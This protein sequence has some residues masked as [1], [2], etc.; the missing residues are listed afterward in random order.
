MKPNR[1]A[2][3]LVI[4]FCLTIFAIGLMFILR[5]A[6]PGRSGGGISPTLA[7]IMTVDAREDAIATRVAEAL[8]QQLGV[9]ATFVPTI[10]PTPLPTGIN[11]D[12]LVTPEAIQDGL[13]TYTTRSGDTVTALGLRFGIENAE[14]IA[15]GA[16]SPTGY[17]PIGQLI[18]VPPYLG[19]TTLPTLLLPDAA[20]VYGPL[21]AGF[22]VSTYV[23]D[24][25][26]YLAHYSENV[27]GTV[28]S[29]ADIVKRVALE[30]SIS[31]KLLLAILEYRSGWVLSNKTSMDGQQYPLG[32][33]IA[34]A[35]GL[36]E[37]LYIAGRQLAYGFYGWRD[38]TRTKIRFTDGSEARLHPEINAGTAAIENL[39][40]SLDSPTAW[41]SHLFGENS[42]GAVYA[43]MFG[44]PWEQS[45]EPLIP[46]GLSQP[47]LELP[48]STGE[49]YH[50]TSGPHR[51][52]GLGSPWA[53]IDFAPAD[54]LKGCTVS[55]Y[56][57]TASAPGL[58]VRSANGVVVIDLDGDGFEQTGWV[59][60]Y[61]HLAE[62]DRVQAGT[63]VEQDQ[64][65]GH[66]SCV[67]GVATGSHVH[68]AR[69]YY[70]EW[71]HAAGEVPLV[72]SGWLVISGDGEYQGKLMREGM[73]VSSY[74]YSIADSRIS[75]D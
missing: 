19:A 18:R 48:F 49:D 6:F 24:A 26:G 32:Y 25:D 39:F 3:M 69:K 31:A 34:D 33:G 54:G 30:H 42:F 5:L 67:G 23:A 37:E 53:A 51:A 68:F 29:G 9:S 59:L 16:S 50:L 44:I 46:D 17:L 45:T 1:F 70:G 74:R 28:L 61:L 55:P 56:W 57:V 12:Y 43:Q 41:N 40:A 35:A 75:R 14:I 71:M 73:V 58:V 11:L 22:D 8:G 27:R 15:G 63:W 10:Q 62:Q 52:W 60:F 47:V 7:A 65:I 4:L 36:Y 38:G 2:M 72:L 13:H 66:A 21:D 20:I 64:K